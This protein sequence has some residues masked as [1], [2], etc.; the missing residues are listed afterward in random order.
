MITEIIKLVQSDAWFGVS[1]NVEI[2]KGQHKI[3]TTWRGAYKYFKRLF[4]W[5]KK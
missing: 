4:K 3:I 1:K 2:A 5:Q